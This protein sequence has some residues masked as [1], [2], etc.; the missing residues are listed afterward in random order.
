[1][2][3]STPLAV[4]QEAYAAFGAGDVGRILGL[5]AVPCDWEFVGPAGLAYAGAR[6]THA[7]IGQFFADVAAADD[8]QTFEPREFIAAGDHVTVLGFQRAVAKPRGRAFESEWVHVFT[9]TDGK[10]VRWRGFYDTAASMDAR[11]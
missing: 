1:M 8:I 4:V 11:R 9:V 5:V 3:T 6:R 2:S 7:Q 10:V